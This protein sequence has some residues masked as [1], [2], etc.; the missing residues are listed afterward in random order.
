M[1]K[2]AGIKFLSLPDEKFDDPLGIGTGA[3]VIFGNTGGVMEAA[4]RTAYEYITGEKAP[5]V[6]YQLE[7]VRGLEAVKEASLQVGD[8]T[9]NVAVIFGTAN[10]RSFIQRMKEGGKRRALRGGDDLSRRLHRRRRTT[11][12]QRI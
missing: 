11:Q 5:Q 1:I 8:L 10:V 2:K 3:G 9:V 12:G 6:L 7:P 4:L